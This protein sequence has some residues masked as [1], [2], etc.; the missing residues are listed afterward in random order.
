MTNGTIEIRLIDVMGGSSLDQQMWTVQS[1]KG[2]GAFL[3]AHAKFFLPLRDMGQNYF[4]LQGARIAK[5]RAYAE[6]KGFEVK[7]GR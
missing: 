1:I 4:A 5:F 2:A 3:R 6:S 7:V